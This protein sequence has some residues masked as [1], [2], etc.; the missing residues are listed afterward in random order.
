M[1]KEIGKLLGEAFYRIPRFQRPYSW[2]HANLEEFW[3]DTIVDNDSDYFIGNFV[4]FQ[5]GDAL[6]VVDGQQRLTTVTIMLC[7]L[8]DVM[9]E[10]GLRDFAQGV[11]FL[12]ERPNIRNEKYYVLRPETSYPFFQEYIQK[13]G[14]RPKT[15][16]T[17]PEEDLLKEA[18]YFFRGN[19]NQLVASIKSQSNLSETKKKAKISEDLSRIRDKVLGLKVIC[20]SLDNDDDAYVIFETLNTR[21]KDLTLSDL[22]KSHLSRLL[23]PTNKGVDLA[24]DKWIEIAKTFEESQADL[25]VSTFIHH[26]WLS[27]YEYVTEK[28]LYKAL[29]KQIKKENAAEFLDDLVRE[30]TIYR[31]I[32]ETSY[33]K[34]KKDD[35]DIRD[36]L[37]AMGLFRIKQQLPMVLAVMRHHTDGTLKPKR[38]KQILSA[39]ENFHFSFTAVASQR[40]SGGISFMYASAARNLHEARTPSAK[41]KVVDGLRKKL[42]SKLPPYGEFEARFLELR[43]SAKFTKQ[44][45]LVRYIL[46]KMTQYNCTGISVDA[47]RMTV[48]HLSPENPPRPTGLSDEQVA[49]L[50]N[51]VLVDSKLNNKLG[52]K[53]FTEKKKILRSADGWLDSTIDRASTWGPV[54]IETRT[55]AL[56]AQA[57]RDVWN[58]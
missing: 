18:Y 20:T 9:Q 36:S 5:D 47:E 42:E 1:D 17:G 52:N 21:G 39:I 49:S 16:E 56:A 11:H 2:D 19:L 46:T 8:R 23:K 30:S 6:G 43:Y 32:H 40:S 35:L 34:W 10:E 24:K 38:V 22:V 13:F 29:R 58:L 15:P 3:N 48:E 4:F 33:K 44:K 41:G 51:L 12:I 57:Y 28:K 37:T 25:S 50:G 53:G 45:N 27:R 31:L 55:K 54:E 7:A 14:R 26:Y